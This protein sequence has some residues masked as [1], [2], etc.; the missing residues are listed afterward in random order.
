MLGMKVGLSSTADE[1]LGCA[2]ANTF[3]KR[4]ADFGT[5]TNGVSNTLNAVETAMI[6][7]LSLQ[8]EDQAGYISN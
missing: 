1:D 4:S 8:A 2:P 5:E 3:K 7:G 6:D